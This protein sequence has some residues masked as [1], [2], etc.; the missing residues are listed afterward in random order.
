MEP[1]RFHNAFL[2]RRTLGRT[3]FIATRLGIGD[4]A[5]RTL[6]LDSCVATVRR[7]IDAGLNVIDTAPGYEE[8]YSEE[9]VGCAL[10]GCRDMMFLIDKIDFP[11]QPI[12]PQ[13]DESLG[14]LQM[15]WVDLFV[16]HGVSDEAAWDAVS[17]PGGAMEQLGECRHAG[18]VRFRGISSHHPDVLE[19]AIASGLC[20]VV[21]F[22]VGAGCDYD[23]ETKV[24]SLARSHDVGTV[25]FKTFGAGKLLADTTGYNQ[26]LRDRPRGKISSGGLETPEVPQLPHMSVADCIHYTLTTD[27]DVTLLGLS[28]PNEQDVAFEAALVFKPLSAACM[29][30][31]RVQASDALE[32]KGTCWWNPVY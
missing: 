16:L 26:P 11:N 3:K 21:L 6:P 8:G 19:D 18:K 7:A 15:D 14:R 25:C 27:P 24:L 17:A 29:A 31:L 30:E 32:G 5:D 20:D 23:Y 9:I 4:V 12:G 13:V 1:D 10:K 2:P 22:P 28:Y